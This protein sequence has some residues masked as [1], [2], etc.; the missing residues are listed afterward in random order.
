[1]FGRSKVGLVLSEAL[2]TAIL[3]SVILAVSRSQ[4]GFPY[5]VALA[6]GLTLALLVLIVGPISGAHVNPAVTL[7]QWSARLISTTNAVLYIAAQFIGAVAAWQLYVYFIDKPLTSIAGKFDWRILLAEA[8]GT[9]VFTFGIAAAVYQKQK[10]GQLAATVGGSLFLG[11]V[12]AS[13]I[14][15]GILN[16]AVAVGV[17]SWNGAYVFGPLIGGLVGF[18]LYALVLGRVSTETV[19]ASNSATVATGKTPTKKV[20]AKKTAK[21]K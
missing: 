3:T 20:V 16:P 5:F 8:V 4:L 21:K 14:S 13:V 12:I 7:A 9:F 19:A 15:N 1:M 6:A 18:N 17:Q 11:V 2:G 10:G